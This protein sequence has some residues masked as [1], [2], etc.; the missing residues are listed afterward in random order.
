[1][2]GIGGRLLNFIGASFRA[3]Y[4]FIRHQIVGG[5]KYT[6]REY[7]Y[8]PEDSDDWFDKKGHAFVNWIIAGVS[9][10]VIVIILKKLGG[11]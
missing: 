4:G 6:F 11:L 5:K 2:N 1:M 7:L 3:C 10:T 8:G 9:L